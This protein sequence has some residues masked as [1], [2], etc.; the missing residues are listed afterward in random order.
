[1]GM[2]EEIQEVERNYAHMDV[3][4]AKEKFKTFAFRWSILNKVKRLKTL[5]RESYDFTKASLEV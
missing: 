3:L 2:M 4:L 1:M 5:D